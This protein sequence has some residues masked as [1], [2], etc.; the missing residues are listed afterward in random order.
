M[1]TKHKVAI[2]Y[3][4]FEDDLPCFTD[5][6]KYSFTTNIDGVTIKLV[7]NFEE[8]EEF[9]S[10]NFNS[11]AAL[12]YY[13]NNLSPE[14]HHEL[15]IKSYTIQLYSIIHKFAES[16]FPAIAK[17]LYTVYSLVYATTVLSEFDKLNDEQQKLAYHVLSQVR[18]ISDEESYIAPVI[19]RRCEILLEQMI[20]N[21]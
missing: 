12:F 7:N 2:I 21:K 1:C 4:P 19:L 20:N 10:S 11:K 3:P 16:I 6:T 17:Y 15:Q 14:E 18:K 9:I 13:D 5:A 8:A